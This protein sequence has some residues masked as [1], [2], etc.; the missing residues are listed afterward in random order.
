LNKNLKRLFFVFM[1]VGWGRRREGR[2]RSSTSLCLLH[3]KREEFCCLI[4]THTDLVVGNVLVVLYNVTYT[5]WEERREKRGGKI[6]KP[7]G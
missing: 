3:T 7:F 5:D 4:N 6:V 1:I 2:K